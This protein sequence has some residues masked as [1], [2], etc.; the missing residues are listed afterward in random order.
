MLHK[1]RPILAQ[2]V[3]G[4]DEEEGG[5]GVAENEAREIGQ[6]VCGG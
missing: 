2:T 6:V 4:Y 3:R 1:P 5:D